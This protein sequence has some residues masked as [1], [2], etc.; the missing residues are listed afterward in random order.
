MK[1][2]MLRRR[3]ARKP[4]RS[5]QSSTPTQE[6]R[7]K[8]RWRAAGPLS[9]QALHQVTQTT[10]PCTERKI[11]TQT[12]LTVSDSTHPSN[13]SLSEREPGER[14]NR[15]RKH[16]PRHDHSNRSV[17]I[18]VV[19]SSTVESSEIEEVGEEE[20]NDGQEE[21]QASASVVGTSPACFQATDSRNAVSSVY[22][23]IP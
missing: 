7:K 8:S 23:H 10:S 5:P 17:L 9:F 2:S 16:G 13:I 20:V 21:S 12:L 19:T 3:S 4:R 1:R 6:P 14:D 11:Q 15:P 18:N 22:A